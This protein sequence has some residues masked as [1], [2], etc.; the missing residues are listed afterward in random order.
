MPRFQSNVRRMKVAAAI[1]VIGL[2]AALVTLFLGYRRIGYIRLALDH[3]AR[4]RHDL[5]EVIRSRR[6]SFR[7]EPDVARALTERAE[8]MRKRAD[9]EDRLSE[10]YRYAA[11]H[12]W[13]PV[14]PDP[15]E[16]D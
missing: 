10:K 14:A 9:N 1:V 11:S 6:D 4:S 15:P 7:A 8:R 13:L 5:V 12:P 2:A 16:P 3:E